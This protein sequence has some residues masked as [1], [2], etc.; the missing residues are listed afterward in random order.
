MQDFLFIKNCGEYLKLPLSEIISVEAVNKYVRIITK[1]KSYL[2]STTMRNI[3]KMLPNN[4]FRRIHRSYIISLGYISKF[5]N[6]AVYIDNKKFPIGKR[7]RGWLLNDVIVL[8]MDS[9]LKSVSS[10]G[11]VDKMLPR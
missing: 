2:I 5:D 10:T 9:K 6:N 11:G 1:K 7:Y 3:E 4:I 8:Y